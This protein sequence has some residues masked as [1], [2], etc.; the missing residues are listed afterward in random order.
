M[1]LRH[2]AL[3]KD[4]VTGGPGSTAAGAPAGNAAAAG[5]A[6][7]AKTG[8]GSTMSLANGIA[9]EGGFV[10]VGLRGAE[11]QRTHY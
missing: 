6:I 3:I 10:P 11:I 8:S 4:A 9:G 2:L 5:T 1:S 7:A